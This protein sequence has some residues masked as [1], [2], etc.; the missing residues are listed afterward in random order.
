MKKLYAHYS[1]LRRIEFHAGGEPV[2]NEKERTWVRDEELV[3]QV[4]V[5]SDRAVPHCPLSLN[6]FRSIFMVYKTVDKV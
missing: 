3:V 1:M 2:N 6:G 4:R 5:C